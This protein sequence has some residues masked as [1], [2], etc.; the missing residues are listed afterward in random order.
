MATVRRD[1]TMLL[2]GGKHDEDNISNE[3]AEYDF[4]SG[5]TKILVG[6]DMDMD[7][8]T[9]RFVSSAVYSGNTLV[10]ISVT[11]DDPVS[12][13]CLNFL[14]NSWKKLP[15]ITKTRVLASAVVVNNFEY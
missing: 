15:S 7:M 14:S 5:Q 2:I 3:I 9:E 6:M 4:K 11:E 10:V 13:D 1:D 12:V 8:E